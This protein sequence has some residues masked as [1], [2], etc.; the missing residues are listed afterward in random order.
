MPLKYKLYSLVCY[1]TI[2]ITAVL[3]IDIVYEFSEARVTFPLMSLAILVLFFGSYFGLPV[4]GLNLLRSVN[5]HSGI[6]NS[7]VVFLRII[8]LIQAIFQIIIA[9]NSPEIFQRIVYLFRNHFRFYRF[10][11]ADLMIQLLGIPLVILSL[12]LEIFTFLLVKEIKRK[13]HAIID[14]LGLLNDPNVP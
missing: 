2:L 11:T 14:E 12:Y 7:A 8:V 13:G 6:K 9:Y 4:F 1:L 5:S 10:S 3:L